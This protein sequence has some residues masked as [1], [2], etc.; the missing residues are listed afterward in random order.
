MSRFFLLLCLVVP[1]A[2]FTVGC[3]G[4]GSTTVLDGEVAK[5]PSLG[6]DY[7]GSTGGDPSA[8]EAK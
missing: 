1:V 5:D 6:D 2:F 3:G 7:T 8:A 4:S